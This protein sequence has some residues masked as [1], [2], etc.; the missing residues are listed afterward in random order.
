[1]L[2]ELVVPVEPRGP[3]LAELVELGVCPT[4]PLG[5]VRGL[6]RAG[7]VTE[8]PMLCCWTEASGVF[9]VEGLGCGPTYGHRGCLLAPPVAAV[10]ACPEAA[11]EAP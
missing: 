11:A 6:L 7:T 3:E 8:S 4:D 5:S 10:E 2:A 9:T 1:M